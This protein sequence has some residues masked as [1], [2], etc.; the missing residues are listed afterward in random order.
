MLALWFQRRA[1]THTLPPP[2]TV[3][4][5]DRLWNFGCTRYG[6]SSSGSTTLTGYINGWDGRLSYS[7]PGNY[8]INRLLSYHDNGKGARSTKQQLEMKEN[9]QCAYCASRCWLTCLP[10]VV[11]PSPCSPSSFPSF[12]SI[13]AL[14]IA[15]FPSLSTLTPSPLLPTLPQHKRTA[16]GESG[17]VASLVRPLPRAPGP[18]T[19]TAGTRTCGIRRQ[20]GTPSQARH[21]ITT[22]AKRIVFGGFAFAG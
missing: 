6:S 20:P 14:L 2:F 10:S 7:C 4:T 13:A 9:G 16:G 19:E 11:S 12:H 1:H 18:T 21:R 3:S 5:E 15:P 22:T 17:A 8:Y